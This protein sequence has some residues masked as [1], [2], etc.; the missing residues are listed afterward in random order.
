MLTG[1][2]P[3]RGRTAQQLGEQH[4]RARANLT[5]LAPGQQV[6]IERALSKNPHDRYPSCGEMVQ[7]LA[8]VVDPTPESRRDQLADSNPDVE[9]DSR[10]GPSPRSSP[11]LGPIFRSLNLDDSSLHATGS[12][13]V[14]SRPPAESTGEDTTGSRLP[15]AMNPVGSSVEPTVFVGLGGI[16]GRTLCAI[17]HLFE[18]R[19]EHRACRRSLGWLF[20]DTDRATIQEVG[21]DDLAG[22]LRDE[23]TVLMPLHGPE[24]YRPQLKQLLGWLGRHWVFR[25]PRSHCTEGIRPLG[26]LALLD[27]AGRV[28]ERLRKSIKQVAS[29]ITEEE[30]RQRLQILV[31]ASISGG[32]GGGCLA[33]VGC[34]IRRI[35]REEQ[36]E[37]ASVAGL[38]VVASS[39]RKEQK[40]LARANAYVTLS[41]L[42]HFLDPS[43]HFPGVKALGL[44]PSVGGKSPFD[45]LFLADL[46]DIV[47]ED[48]LE[49]GAQ[50]VAEYVFFCRGSARAL[51]PD[52]AREAG[53]PDSSG[54][55]SFRLGRLGFPR[56]QLR[57][58]TALEV[59]RR[60][61]DRR[62]QGPPRAAAGTEPAEPRLGAGQ[63]VPA[64][65]ASEAAAADF[66]S[67]SGLDEKHFHE[68]FLERVERASGSDPLRFFERQAR[69]LMQARGR[70]SQGP[71]F[72]RFMDEL[73]ERFGPG[74]GSD[75]DQPRQAP[76]EK[77]LTDEFTHDR[78]ALE[79]RM[80]A[81]VK[82]I[83]DDLSGGV[84]PARSALQALGSELASQL[85]ASASRIEEVRARRSAIRTR[86]S[87]L[88]G[89][90][91]SAFAALRRQPKRDATTQIE[92]L[93]EY[94]QLWIQET[95]LRVRA[96]IVSALLARR[97]QVNSRLDELRQGL[98]S[99]K[100]FFQSKEARFQDSR[101][102][103]LG[104]SIDLLPAG[105]VRTGSV[106]ELLADSFCSERRLAEL[107]RGLWREL[108]EPHGGLVE[109][110]TRESKVVSEVFESAL[111]QPVAS[112]VDRWLEVQDAASILPERRGSMEGA[113]REL[114]A[115]YRSLTGGLPALPQPRVIVGTPC[116]PSGRSLRES[117]AQSSSLPT[118][119]EDIAIADDVVLCV[120]QENLSLAAT[121]DG[122]VARQPWLAELASKL[123]T[124]R[125]VLWTGLGRAGAVASQVDSGEDL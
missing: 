1:V 121:A 59:C 112:A 4:Q 120:E 105:P 47:V 95:A 26:R 61:I 22:R 2:R 81:W 3:F 71:A 80:E 115:A 99:V 109:I 113:L 106:R 66:F 56:A 107:E 93:C 10:L 44:G 86:L 70:E 24:Y 63:G 76:F 14:E 46:G 55:R 54:L 34:L 50:L 65:L 16:A 30:G 15:W 100:R 62:I 51:L 37:C 33:D 39:I 6:V 108:R 117:L 27:N 75:S 12:P 98:E 90:C 91:K 84:E 19:I 29:Q 94:G 114:A 123:V 64:P 5:V 118:I 49:N 7:A 8:V 42:G 23:E 116:S 32:T 78:C 41:E 53:R 72:V 77:R 104:W 60:V 48:D 9:A 25:I 125:D 13:T 68:L 85:D 52:P 96:E 102:P 20:L 28:T 97:A 79:R 74:A 21:Q 103:A 58:M 67:R 35:L 119:A 31:V 11:S 17:K 87:C 92:E 36:L 57:K 18:A 40:E 43:C 38:L 89:S 110:M 111:L 73:D 82:D 83:V 69:S 45:P 122:L 101:C 88:S 124:R